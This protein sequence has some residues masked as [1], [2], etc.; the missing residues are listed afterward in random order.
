MPIVLPATAALPNPVRMRTSPIHDAVPMKFW[1]VAVPEMRRM[2]RITVEIEAA[3]AAV[4]SA[5]GR[6][7]RDQMNTADT[8]RRCRGRSSSPTAAP[9]TPSSGK[10]ADAEDQARPED[11]VDRVREPQHAHRDRG[12]ARAAEDGVDEEEQHHGAAA[13]QHDA[14][15]RRSGREAHRRSRP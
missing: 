13:A 7:A 5:D 6:C 4:G 3:D 2:P 14:R 15:E 1:N 11:D 9:V 10:R 12:I 8:A